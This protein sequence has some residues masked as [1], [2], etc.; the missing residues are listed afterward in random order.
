MPHEQAGI[1]TAGGEV[2]VVGR[3]A[4]RK[5]RTFPLEML[6]RRFAANPPQLDPAVTG[7]SQPA[8]VTQPGQTRR[9]AGMIVM[10]LNQ[11]AFVLPDLLLDLVAV[12]DVQMH[13]PGIHHG[14]HRIQPELRTDLFV[15]E[16]RLGHRGRIGQA[17]G[18][19]EDGAELVAPAH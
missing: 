15:H 8:P 4:Q 9:R 7:R 2:F 12:V 3:N 18:L 14:D 1:L 11:I 6:F 13:V 5:E 16:E 19:D 17:G 10:H